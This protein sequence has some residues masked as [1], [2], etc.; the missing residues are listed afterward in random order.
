MYAMQCTKLTAANETVVCKILSL[1]E[2]ATVDRHTSRTVKEFTATVLQLLVGWDFPIVDAGGHLS[3]VHF[4]LLLTAVRNS[5]C[6]IL[7]LAPAKTPPATP[8]C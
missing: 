2:R 8:T 4:P 7:G 6:G 5:S 1:K 3:L